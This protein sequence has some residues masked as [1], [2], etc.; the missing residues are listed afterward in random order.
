MSP[1]V[2]LIVH[3]TAAIASVVALFVTITFLLLNN[4]RKIVNVTLSLTA[5]A[6]I[7]FLVSHVL[8][9]SVPDSAFS[10]EILMWNLSV[11][12]IAVFNFHCVMAAL[13]RNKEKAW[14]IHL[15]YAVGIGL[16]IFYLIF[17]ET[18]I[19]TSVPKM[20]FPNYYVPGQ[21]HWVMRVIFQIIL[22]F[23]FVYELARAYRNRS[24]P[25]ERTRILYFAISLSLGWLFGL[26][27]LFLIWNI[28]INPAY[29]FFSVFLFCIPFTYAVLKY[30]LLDIRVVAKR[31]FVYGFLVAIVG[32]I[33]ALFNYV[34]HVFQV[35]YPQFP[36]WIISFALGIVIVGIGILIWRQLRENDILKYEFITTVT[37]KFR[38]PLTHI[39][40]ASENL[41]KLS[42]SGEAQE[43]I[44]FI[45]M[46][47]TKL[48]EL[49][50]LLVNASETE[51]AS[52]GYNLEHG[53][54]GNAVSEVIRYLDSQFK[55]KNL[56]VVSHLH[57]A[58]AMFDT[59]RL[60]FVIQVLIEN[61]IQYTPEGGTL[62]I[63]ITENQ[64]NVTLSVKDSGIGISKDEL[65]LLFSKLYRGKNARLADTE[66]MGI[67]LFVSKEIIRRHHGKIW[68]DS[69]GF[70]K[71]SIFNFSLPRVA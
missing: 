16:A 33:I 61:A 22:P 35:L 31:A 43:Q 60:K 29:G 27:P 3:N 2:P 13:G 6:Y 40:W 47:N 54:L 1:N 66:G 70:N 65:P 23:F 48:V 24:E 12:F 57:P 36:F 10:R 41:S 59:T 28:Q 5:L 69:E 26:L 68:A 46:A 55:S 34:N 37:H 58:Y 52:Y 64:K 14:L 17:P 7:V 38:T 21:F 30:E 19:L 50:D 44:K 45:Q 53:D 49:T 62:D 25:L 63:S 56:N 18:F 20:Y 67:G 9:V 39:K 51:H 32:S 71:G 4:H 42:T 11:I 8:G 15:V